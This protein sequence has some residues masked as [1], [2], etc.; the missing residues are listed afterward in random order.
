VAVDGG[1]NLFI[2]D[3]DNH[4][5]R[6]VDAATQ[7]ITTVAGN[8]N[9]H[10][11]GDG[12]PASMASLRFPTG[13]AV[14]AAGNLFIADE[15]NYRV[16]R[17]DAATQ[18]IT[19]VA[20]SG[21]PDFDGED[22]GP[23]TAA[24]MSPVGVAVDATSD[25]FMAD[26]DNNCVRRVDMATGTIATVAGVCS[27][28]GSGQGSFDGDGGP[29][30]AAHLNGPAGVAV[31]RAGNVAIADS[32][33][34]R[35]RWVHAETQIILTVAGN[36]SNGFSGDGGLATAAALPRSSHVAVD[37]DGNV[38]VESYD[39]VRRVTGIPV[40]TTATTT[41]TTTRPS[42]FPITT[43]SSTSRPPTTMAR[44]TNTTSTTTT[45]PPK[46]S[47]T[48]TTLACLGSR[49]ALDVSLR[50]HDCAIE[51]VP[52]GIIK[53][54]EKAEHLIEQADGMPKRT[55]KQLGHARRILDRAA[56]A[57][58]RAARGRTPRLP[59]NCADAIREAVDSVRAGLGT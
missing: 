37:A 4:R 23:A 27:F 3:A 12:G 26:I 5:V 1:E 50:K 8:G 59:S 17:V 55:R 13:V 49:C 33:N 20:G 51:S 25:L 41:S 21:Q 38:L 58:S 40:P 57:A 18:I 10:F 11:S 2:A 44:S 7:I 53:R 45:S 34:S 56:K 22:G 15:A 46:T 54:F 28:T 39:R 42:Q 24:G 6:R 43:T 9:P 16:R 32:G 47:T 36:G 19:T 30:R 48:T 31:D 35:I 29:A 52:V 14:D